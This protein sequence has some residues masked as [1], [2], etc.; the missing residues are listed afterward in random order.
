MRE[1][2]FKNAINEAMHEEM[3]R[4]ETVY[5]I[6]ENAS[7]CVWGTSDGLYEKLP[8]AQV[9]GLPSINANANTIGIALG[10]ATAAGIAG[11][12]LGRAVTK[13]KRKGR[14]G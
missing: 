8:A 10:A 5:L 6:G 12:A 3:S 7:Q 13:S 2:M 11:H 9:P 14:E 4:N 1:I